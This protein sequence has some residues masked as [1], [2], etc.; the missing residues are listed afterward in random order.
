[1]S[2]SKC[3]CTLELRNPHW[4][5]RE[6]RHLSLMEENIQ[7]IPDSVAWALEF[8]PESNVESQDKYWEWVIRDINQ[9]KKRVYPWVVVR[10]IFDKKI[11]W[12][13]IPKKYVQELVDEIGKCG[14]CA[15]VLHNP[16]LFK[17]AK[18]EDCICETVKQWY[19]IPGFVIEKIADR[20]SFDHIK[21]LRW[22]LAINTDT[23]EHKSNVDHTLVS[24]LHKVIDGYFYD[25]ISEEDSK[26]IVNIILES[27]YYKNLLWLLWPDF[28]RVFQLT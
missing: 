14:E 19:R 4:C 16:N 22:L 5:N 28:K 3:N 2:K 15:L 24:Y 26:A 27:E 11:E 13:S 21:F 18:I 20:K 23:T 25:Q 17:S 10:E 1:M 6:P 8:N 9:A 12:K 7:K